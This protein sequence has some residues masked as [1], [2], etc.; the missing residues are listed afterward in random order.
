M[1]QPL[2]GFI[3]EDTMVLIF[4]AVCGGG[5]YLAYRFLQDNQVWLVVA[6]SLTSLFLGIVIG[7]HQK[8]TQGGDA[9]E[10]ETSQSSSQAP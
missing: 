7:E 9:S 8:T 4:S 6:T 1:E 2:K 5:V 3:D 10:S